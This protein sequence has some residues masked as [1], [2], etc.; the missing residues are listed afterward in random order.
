MP[1]TA[2]PTIRDLPIGGQAVLEGVMMRAPHAWAVAVRLPDTHPTNPGGISVTTEP[3]RP[4]HR[5]HRALRLPIIRGAVALV[6]SMGIGVRALGL[7][8]AAAVAD[9][10]GGTDDPHGGAPGRLA[11]ALTV[12]AGLAFA[13][14]LFFLLP[15]TITKLTLGDRLEHGVSFVAAEKLIRLTIFLGYL[16]LISRFSHLQRLFQYHA[17][18]HQTIACLEAGEPLTPHHAAHYSRLHPRCGTSFMFLVMIVSFLVF[19]PLGNLPLGWL[20][21]SRIAGVPLVAGLTFELIKWIGRHRDQRFARALR[22]PGM[23]LQRLTTRPC[24][25]PQLEVA[26]AA[27]VAATAHGELA[28]DA[29]LPFDLAA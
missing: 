20:L 13:V 14:S 6:E 24:D 25:A 3:L 1:A 26:I 19:A 12:A 5:R 21:L 18:E 17:A 8:A 22:W 27:L 15:A 16:T 11:W 7:S 23:Q 4:L 10:P 28:S 9:D 2:A 29:D